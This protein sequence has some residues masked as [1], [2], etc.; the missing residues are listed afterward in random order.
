MQRCKGQPTRNC[1]EWYRTSHGSGDLGLLWKPADSPGILTRRGRQSRMSTAGSGAPL[2][3]SVRRCFCLSNHSSS[4]ERA[5]NSEH[6]SHAAAKWNA[7]GTNSF[8]STTL[9]NSFNTSIGTW[10]NAN[11]GGRAEL[12]NQMDLSIDECGLV[13]LRSRHRPRAVAFSCPARSATWRHR[14]CNAPRRNA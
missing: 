12:G 5:L 3:S 1:H 6:R 13:A 2:P 10:P 9:P 11:G 7:N 14:P 4:K 8:N